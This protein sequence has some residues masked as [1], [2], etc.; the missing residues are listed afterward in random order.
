MQF[1]SGKDGIYQEK[2]KFY[3]ENELFYRKNIINAI[4]HCKR[5]LLSGKTEILP[6]KRCF[7]VTKILKCR[8]TVENMVFI[9]KTINFSS[10]RNFST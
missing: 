3:L 8:F 2:Q 10:K 4:L 7:L 1:Y 5:W 6:R 9:M